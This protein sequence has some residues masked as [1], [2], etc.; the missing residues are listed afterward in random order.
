MSLVGNQNA[1]VGTTNPNYH[2]DVSGNSH[3]TG[4][5]YTLGNV[6][7][8]TTNPLYNLDVNGT[9]HSDQFNIFSNTETLTTLNGN[10]LQ[11]NASTGILHNI[12]GIEISRINATGKLV[13]HHLIL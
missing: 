8:G 5:S 1:G 13:N 4:N 9:T 10:A 6:G 11:I 3:V 12:N 7:I 2:I